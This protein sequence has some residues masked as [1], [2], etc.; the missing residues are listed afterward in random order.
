MLSIVVSGLPIF[1]PLAFAFAIQEIPNAFSDHNGVH[2]NNIESFWATLKRGIYG[3]Y[4][5]VSIN[6]SQRYV[7]KNTK[8]S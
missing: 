2:T 1:D 4:H 5:H 8:K 6:Y 3:I 7:R